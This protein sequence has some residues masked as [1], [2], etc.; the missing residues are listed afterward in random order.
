MLSEQQQLVNPL[1]E[2][3]INEHEVVIFA[4][5]WC[6]YCNRTKTLFKNSLPDGDVKVYDIDTMEAGDMIQDD[7]YK[8]TGQ[9]TVP[10][11]WVNG[12]FLGGNSETQTAWKNG[13][14]SALLAGDETPELQQ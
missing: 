11:V 8:M 7:L 14:L 1:I 5:T 13:Q 3:A 10:S 2:S 12:K 4:K 6:P 9:G